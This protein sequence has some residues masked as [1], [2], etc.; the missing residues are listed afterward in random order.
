M[1]SARH[2]SLLGKET[3]HLVQYNK[4]DRLS[5]AIINSIFKELYLR[6]RVAWQG[7]ATNNLYVP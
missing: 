4:P 2:E 7:H 3:A 5:Y 1:W 6:L